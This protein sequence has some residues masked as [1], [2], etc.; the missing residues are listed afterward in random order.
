MK[1]YN[2]FKAISYIALF[3]SFGLLTSC[4]DDEV[5]EVKDP[6][7]SFQFTVTPPPSF[8]EVTFMNFSQNATSYSWDFGDDTGRST[9]ENPTYTYSETGTYTVTLTASNAGGESA[10]FTDDVNIT[11]PLEAQRALIGD[12]GKVWQLLADNSTGVNPLQVGPDDR[13]TVWFALADLCTRACIF[14]DTWTFNTDGTYSF[15]NNGDF[16]GEE[17]VWPEGLEA[18]CFDATNPDNFKGPND[19]DLSAWDSGMNDF[20]YDPST[21]TLIITG[22]FIGLTK[23]GS[24]SDDLTEPA[25]S[26]MYSVVKL[27]DVENGVDTLVLETDLVATNGYWAFTLVHY[28]NEMDKVVVEECVPVAKTIIDV[29]DIDFESNPPSWNTFGGTDSNGAGVDYSTVA[30]PV[31]G[32]I[33]TS[34]MVG[35]LDEADGSAGWSGISTQLAG[36]VDFSTKTTFKVKVYSPFAGAVIKFK[37]E[38]SADANI[39][40]EIDLMTTNADTWEE[41]SFTFAAEDSEKFDVLV[42]FFDFQSD[43]KPASRTHYFDEILF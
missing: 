43:V 18:T 12:N 14:D 7:A 41:L 39:N 3:T 1:K 40:K 29:V 20:V 17:G 22:G 5:D 9:D 28:D 33:N 4:G 27:V 30:N 11:D 21:N 10:E 32:G 42:L 23:V 13:S 24:T 38:D 31:S 2:Q 15:E 8:L 19:E 26:V 25:A 6:I 35:K 16:W 37:L 34:S 36:Y